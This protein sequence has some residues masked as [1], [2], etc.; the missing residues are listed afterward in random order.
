MRNL[1]AAHYEAANAQST[2]EAWIVLV[3]LSNANLTD[4]IRVASDPKQLLPVA[5]VRGVISRGQE[6]IYLPFNINLPTQDD[7]GTSRARLSIDN[8]SR[9]IVQAVETARGEINCLVEVVLAS[10]TD[11]VEIA[12]PNFQLESVSYDALVVEGDLAVKTLIS[13]PVPWGR[14]TPSYFPGLF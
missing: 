4:D 13:E 8:I 9:E 7:T 6:F 11:A 10:D 1:S 3:T 14:F 5:G 2:S 12:Q